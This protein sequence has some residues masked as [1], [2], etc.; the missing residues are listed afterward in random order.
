VVNLPIIIDYYELNYS[1]I[2]GGQ[3]FFGSEKISNNNANNNFL[4]K[5]LNGKTKKIPIEVES[6][7]YT[8]SRIVLEN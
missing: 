6:S 7:N 5:L 1:Y 8:K 3:N 4:E 2:L